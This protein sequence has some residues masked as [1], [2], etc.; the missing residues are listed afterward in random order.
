MPLADEQLVVLQVR[1]AGI[2]SRR[3]GEDRLRLVEL[4]LHF[5]R[6]QIGG[7]AKNEP[8]LEERRNTR[9]AEEGFDECIPPLC[10]SV[11]SSAKP[12]SPS[13]DAARRAA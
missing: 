9:R 7:A 11:L 4:V 10:R 2:H 6:V 5:F 1:V 8:T 3:G 12:S 13:C